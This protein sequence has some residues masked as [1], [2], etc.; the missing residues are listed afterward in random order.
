[1]ESAAVGS[2]AERPAE[3]VLREDLRQAL[4]SRWRIS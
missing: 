3:V 4:S 2:L 1:M